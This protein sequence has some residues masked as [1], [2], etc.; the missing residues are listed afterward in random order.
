[1]LFCFFF[2]FL[3]VTKVR[4]SLGWFPSGSRAV[5]ERFPSGSPAVLQR[6]SQKRW[7]QLIEAGFRA[8][9][10]RVIAQV[11]F[12]TDTNW[13]WSGTV[14]VLLSNFAT[15]SLH[16]QLYSRLANQLTVNS[17]AYLIW[18]VCSYIPIRYDMLCRSKVTVLNQILKIDFA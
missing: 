4:F 6:F 17:F 2:P 1:V 7:F 11:L 16:S 9:S 14:G 8:A 5:P 18:N 3:C 12:S 10:E 15:V 13:I